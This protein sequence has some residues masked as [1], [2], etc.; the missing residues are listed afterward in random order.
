MTLYQ[1]H[2]YLDGGITHERVHQLKARNLRPE[3]IDIQVVQSESSDKEYLVG[4]VEC[5]TKPFEDADV[6]EDRTEIVVCS[7]DDWY[8]NRSAGIEVDKDPSTVQPCKHGTAAYKE[9]RAQ[10]D[11]KQQTL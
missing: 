6:S 2:L 10:E 3:F 5:L 8:F 9:L 7:C 4:R 11:G 1:E